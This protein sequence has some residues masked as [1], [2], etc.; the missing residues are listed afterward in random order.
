MSLTGTPFFVTAI[1]VSVIAALLPLALWS[2]LRGPVVVR[3][4]VRLG[5]VAFAQI[6]AILV[7]FVAVNNTNG[8]YDSWGDLL[9]TSD[10]VDSAIDLGPDG[11]GGRRVSD[12]PKAEQSF[13]PVDDAGMG[14]GIRRAML[15]GRISG[16]EAE[17]YVWLPPQY[18]DPA[19][20]DRKFPVVELLSGF[21]GSPK[22]WFGSL[23]VSKQLEPL[24][25]SGRVAPFIL[26]SP[27]TTLL[28]D[29]DTGCA[30]V[31]GRVNAESWLSIDVR[32][33]VIDNFRA[34]DRADGWAVAGYSAGAHCA[35]KLTVAHPDR[36]RYAISMS[37]YNDPAAEPSSLTA[38]DPALRH[39]ANPLNMLREAA[40]PPR[41]TMLFTGD[42]RDGFQQGVALREAAKAPTRI[43]V[44]QV[45]GG[46]RTST[47][48]REVPSVFEW[49][50]R[51]FE[52][53]GTGAGR[54]TGSDAGAGSGT[55][56]DA[57][58][59]SETGSDA[60]AG[61]GR[62]TGQGFGQGSGQGPDRGAGEQ[63][64]TSALT[65]ARR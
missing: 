55:G 45:K 16:V 59:G 29:T 47:W 32:Q 6:T 19:F 52:E 22:S 23:D 14:S 31:P 28:G 54:G 61:A 3:G 42:G 34:A 4:A 58:A 39:A 17:V 24:M 48:V 43:D 46:H 9:G 5:M 27:R 44:R 60:G 11:T 37:G 36:Y 12:L 50:T 30:N 21:P 10:H 2:R 13:T 49:L 35:A 38:K 63:G 25:R 53:Q 65:A 7:V 20:K 64:G 41:I 1:V 26:V 8:L 57:G 51:R 56:S 40:V 33:M 62:G 15:K 18:D